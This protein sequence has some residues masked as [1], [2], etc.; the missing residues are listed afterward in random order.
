MTATIKNNVL[1][2]TIDLQEP[3]P[4][5]S[6]KSLLIANSH[7]AQP[8]TAQFGGKVVKVS[9]NAYVKAN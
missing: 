3:A 2:I 9:V 5:T 4:S 1:T 7:G 8:T 6:G